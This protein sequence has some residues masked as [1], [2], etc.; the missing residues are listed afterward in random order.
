M[1][2]DLWQIND[3]KKCHTYMRMH[4]CWSTVRVGM[5]WGLG[6]KKWG[7]ARFYFYSSRSAMNR[8]RLNGVGSAWERRDSCR[9]AWEM[10]HPRQRSRRSSHIWQHATCSDK[11]CAHSSERAKRWGEGEWIYK[12]CAN[13]GKCDEIRTD[14]TD[15]VM[16][17]ERQVL[18]KAKLTR[19]KGKFLVNINFLLKNGLLCNLYRCRKI[20]PKFVQK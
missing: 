2:Y 18:K 9:S 19:K 14:P 11:L 20:A 13:W 6:A 8:D 5:W 10:D 1:S 17:G 3:L 4:T 16:Q 15:T 7:E 12:V